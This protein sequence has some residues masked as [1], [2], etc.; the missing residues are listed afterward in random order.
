MRAAVV[1]NPMVRALLGLDKRVMRNYLNNEAVAKL[2]IGCGKHYLNGWLNA[3][4][5]P[6]AR[7][8][9]WLDAK[10]P[11]PFSTGIFQFVYSEHLIEHLSYEE[12]LVMLS[13]CFRVLKQGGKIRIA[14]P[15]FKFLVDLYRS[16]KSALEIAYIKWAAEVFLDGASSC[17]AT[18]VINNFMR[19]WEHQLIYDAEL[20]RESLVKAG[21]GEITR[22]ELNESE[23]VELQ[24]LEHESRLP[25]GFVRL[26]SMI[27][28]ARK[29]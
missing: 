2:H 10:R 26:E 5:V 29:I 7:H 1:A 6:A 11:F 17:E 3:D 23:D 25:A 27:L 9:L 20:L 4:L 14:T 19:A 12:G 18:L 13:E 8:V 16:E 22:C 21:F 28:E 15:D 24:G